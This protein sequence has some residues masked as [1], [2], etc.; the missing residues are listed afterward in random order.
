MVKGTWFSQGIALP[1][2]FHNQQVV[3]TKD[4]EPWF[5]FSLSSLCLLLY[6]QRLGSEMLF[7]LLAHCGVWRQ[8]T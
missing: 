1:A 3:A 4:E 5:S 6:A 2:G 8:T 7:Y